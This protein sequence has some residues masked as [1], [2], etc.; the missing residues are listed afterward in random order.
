MK[1]KL[2][3][4]QGDTGK[5]RTLDGR[6]LAKSHPALEAV[7]T[8]DALR[9]QTAL[10]R[11]QLQKKEPEECSEINFL[12]FLLHTYPLIGTAISDPYIHKP[13][14]RRGELE[15]KHLHFLEEE[16]KRLEA[17]LNLPREFIVSAT[18]ILAAQ[19]DCTAVAARTFERRLVA[20]CQSTPDFDIPICLA[21][22]NRMSDYFFVLARYLEKGHHEVVTYKTRD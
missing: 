6:V 17:E 21:F 4:G 19:A 7:G 5:T 8:L 20:F 10:L 11:L 13:E 18:N 12:L 1:S 3:T 14:W 15:E 22:T 9:T 16:Q 2:T